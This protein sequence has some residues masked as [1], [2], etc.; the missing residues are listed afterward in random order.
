V[1]RWPAPHELT[2]ETRRELVPAVDEA[3]SNAI[4][5]AYAPSPSA[6]DTV[7]VTL[8]TEDAAICVEI[9]DRGQWW[10]RLPRSSPDAAGR[11]A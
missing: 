4:E 3:V 11:C 9:V 1:R 8:L 6:G 7:D 5:H 2:E 10:R